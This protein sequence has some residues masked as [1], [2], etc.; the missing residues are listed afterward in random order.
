M[1]LVEKSVYL[2]AKMQNATL[3]AFT[4]MAVISMT[5]LAN[6]LSGQ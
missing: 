5:K 1:G 6:T 4:C 2:F 3:M